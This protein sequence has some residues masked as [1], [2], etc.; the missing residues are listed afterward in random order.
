MKDKQLIVYKESFITK[1]FRLFK[2]LFGI[3]NEDVQ[4]EYVA[5]DDIE[6]KKNEFLEGIKVQ[7]SSLE[8]NKREKDE[9]DLKKLPLKDLYKLEEYYASVIKKNEEEINLLKKKVEAF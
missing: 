1:I 9:E 3:T 6:Q 4:Y 2:N 8:A 5:I 7:P